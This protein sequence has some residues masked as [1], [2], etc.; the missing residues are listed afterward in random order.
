MMKNNMS[1][2]QSLYKKFIRL[3]LHL[4]YIKVQTTNEELIV[5]GH[6]MICIIYAHYNP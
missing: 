5:F 2:N 1:T 6:T 3:P 4:K